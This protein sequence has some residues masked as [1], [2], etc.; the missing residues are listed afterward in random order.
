[1]ME[2]QKREQLAGDRKGMK[3][4]EIESLFRDL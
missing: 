2:M 1:M 3:N 4:K